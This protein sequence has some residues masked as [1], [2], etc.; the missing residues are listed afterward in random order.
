MLSEWGLLNSMDAAMKCTWLKEARLS[1][2]L[3]TKNLTKL[4]GLSNSAS[5][6]HNHFIKRMSVHPQKMNWL[7][8]IGALSEFFREHVYSM[9]TDELA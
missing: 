9:N 1:A 2:R 3:S 6:S 7:S 8:V 5:L 4:P